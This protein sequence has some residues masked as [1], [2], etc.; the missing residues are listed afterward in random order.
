VSA[1]YE[2]NTIKK[3]FNLRKID[4]FIGSQYDKEFG[5]EPIEN[6]LKRLTLGKFDETYQKAKEKME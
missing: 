2:W 5:I 1:G 4:D 3:I 6:V